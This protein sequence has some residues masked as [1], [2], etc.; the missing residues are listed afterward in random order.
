MEDALRRAE[1]DFLSLRRIAVAGVSRDGRQ[2]SNVIYR[3]LRQEGYDVSPVNPVADQV[4][5]D[6]CYASL[7]DIPGGVDGV[8]VVTHPDAAAEVVRECVELGIRRVWFHRSFGIGSVS[9]EAAQ[10][11][12]REGIT[13]IQGGCPMMFL[14]PV[15][16]PHRCIR[17][18]LDVTGKLPAMPA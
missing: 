11:C 18:V 17:W 3:R 1:T 10:V 8:V 9:D 6:R 12:A 13:A 16:L 15:D 2:A 14:E 7:S 5:G 4:E